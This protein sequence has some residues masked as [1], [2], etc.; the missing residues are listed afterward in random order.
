MDPEDKEKSRPREDMGS[1]I[2]A[3]G[4]KPDVLETSMPQLTIKNWFKC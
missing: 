2:D 1:T 3:K 4:L